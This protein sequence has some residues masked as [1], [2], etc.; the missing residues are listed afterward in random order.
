MGTAI[1]DPLVTSAMS[2]VHQRFSTNTFPSWKLAHTYRYIAHNGEINTI[3]G[4]VS[5]M[6]A[7]QS[8]F[9]SDLYGDQIEKLP[10]VDEV[11]PLVGAR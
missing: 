3:K 4:N 7:R 8:V 6:N 1:A 9:W 11:A 5:W 2:L 10:G